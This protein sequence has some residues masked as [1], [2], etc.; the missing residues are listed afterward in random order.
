[1]AKYLDEENVVWIVTEGEYSD[2]HICA[3]FNNKELAKAFSDEQ[4]NIERWTLNK[5]N[6]NTTY[7]EVVLDGDG[8]II[9]T[10]RKSGNLRGAVGDWL[11]EIKMSE[12]KHWES[13]R[14]DGKV[15]GRSTKSIQE[16]IHRAKDHWTGLRSRE[17]T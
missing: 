6:R 17:V 7:Y 3:V 13:S 2:Y 1:M 15:Y 9:N 14:W 12:D 8:E 5:E 11:A 10:E 4:H 16:A